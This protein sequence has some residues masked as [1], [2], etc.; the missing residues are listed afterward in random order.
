MELVGRLTRRVSGERIRRASESRGKIRV[1]TK[2]QI[3]AWSK[4]FSKDTTGA[5]STRS[6]SSSE[7]EESK[8]HHKWSSNMTIIGGETYETLTLPHP[9]ENKAYDKSKRAVS[10]QLKSRFNLNAQ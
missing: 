7:G 3:A 5:H 6:S 4:I 10:S 1:P 8:K 2:D 9:Y